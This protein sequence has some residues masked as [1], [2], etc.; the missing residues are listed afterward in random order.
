MDKRDILTNLPIS[1]IASIAVAPP[2]HLRGSKNTI[3]DH[4]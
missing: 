4:R 1:F 3:E 2:L